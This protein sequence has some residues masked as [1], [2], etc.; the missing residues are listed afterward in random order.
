MLPELF[1]FLRV[2]L[3]LPNFLVAWLFRLLAVCLSCSPHVRPTARGTEVVLLSRNLGGG[4]FSFL[5]DSQRFS[6]AHRTHAIPQHVRFQVVP[7]ILAGLVY[8]QRKGNFS[9]GSHIRD[10]ACYVC[11]AFARA[12]EP[13]VQ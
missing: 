7:H 5:R 3:Y 2:L 13:Q 1:H 6:N 10:A 8:D 12:Y 9:I 4:D 11:W